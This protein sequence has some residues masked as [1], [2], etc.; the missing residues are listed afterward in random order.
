MEANT[1]ARGSTTLADFAEQVW[2][3]GGAITPATLG[4][5]SELSAAWREL[6]RAGIEVVRSLAAWSAPRQPLDR[7]VLDAIV[8]HV[9]DACDAGIDGAYLMLH[10]S[11]VAREDD[12]PEGT[13]LTA[14][15][16]RLGPDRPIAISLDCHANLTAG[17]VDAADVITAYRTCPHLDTARTGAAAASLLIRALGG[18]IKPVTASAA[19]P[20]ITPPQ[21]HD[22]EQEPFRTLMRRCDELE[23]RPGVLA[24][25]LLLVQPWIDVEGM[26]WKAVIT[27]DGDRALAR[28]TAEELIDAAWEVREGFLAGAAPPVDDALAQALA[29]QAPYVFSDAGDA[30]NGGT[31]GDSTEL[32]RAVARS[33]TTARVLLSVT[34]PQAAAIAL[35]AG[36]GATVDLTLGSGE[37]GDYNEPVSVRGEV[38]TTFDGSFTYTHPV[39]A[40]YRAST[41]PAAL[42][43]SGSTDIV[44][45]TR[46]VGLIDPSLYVALGADPSAYQVVQAKSHVSYRAG[47]DPVT[48]RSVIAATPGPSTA[49]LTRLPYVKRPRPL[50]PFERQTSA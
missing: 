35:A 38:L 16:K 47:F 18:E 33:G 4:P 28:D 1:F 8:G 50:F 15:R 41:G 48:P 36:V 44:V 11:A 30:T 34:E 27:T 19:R 21:M 37:S 7:E 42:V 3:V 20:M 24:A 22:N 5:Q 9:V 17:M 39:N 46:S 25:A 2:A 40:G 10:G 12:D 29:G 49:D 14:L 45:H 43:R 23:R 31:V 26:S 6:D 13:L 32:L